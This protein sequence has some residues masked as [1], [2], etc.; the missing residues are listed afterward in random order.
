MDGRLIPTRLELIPAEEPDQMTVIEILE[1]KFNEDI[2]D[3][4]FSQQNMKRLR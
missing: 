1:I 2:Q 3:S 4:F